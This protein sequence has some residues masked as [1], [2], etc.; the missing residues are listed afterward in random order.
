MSS[1]ERSASV[2]A[3]NDTAAR[4]AAL[5]LLQDVLRRRQSVDDA[6]DAAAAGLVPRDRAFVRLLVATTL[7]RLGQIDV[8]LAGLVAK[9]PPERVTDLLRLGAAQI[10]FLGTPAYAAVGTAVTLAK[11]GNAHQAGMVNAVL[12]R[13]SENG[14]R[15][16]AS[17][18]AARLNTPDW[19][20]NSWVSGYG[21]PAAQATAE[22]HLKEAAL[23]LTLKD[24]STLSQWAERLEA[25]PLPT[26]GLRRQNSGR[27]QD[28]PGFAES[29]WWV[30]DAAAALPAKIL[31][32][33]LGGGAEKVVADLC[34]APGGKTAQL[35]AAECKVIAV[36]VSAARM[37]LLSDN[38]KRLALTAEIVRA[39]ALTWKPREPVDAILLDAPCSATGT[40]RRHPDLPQL[41]S[42]G[43]AAVLAKF[44]TML[45]TAA[46][47]MVKPGGLILYSV[48]SLQAEERKAVVDAV[49]AVRTDLAREKIPPEAVAGES[50]FLTP[51]GELRTLP[52]QWPERG[53]LDGFYVALLRRS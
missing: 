4:A 5:I 11:Q 37:N 45:L 43:D 26:G 52:S 49:L 42:A 21:E 48:C 12:R 27:I 38:L 44:Q 31:L 6:F 50:Q 32:Y 34:A 53:G 36:D 13:V 35:A 14:P 24:P 22:A 20:W 9:R 1:T 25:T 41:K 47:D 8:A 51:S 28:L 19:M 17:Q 10:L 18:D 39:D 15:L 23:D 7:R 33:A 46:A 3:D 16:V 2:S 40:I 30:Q 29:A